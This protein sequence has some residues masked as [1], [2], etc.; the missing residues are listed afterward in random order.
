MALTPDCELGG[1]PPGRLESIGILKFLLV[2]ILYSPGPQ[3]SRLE[4]R[5][6]PLAPIES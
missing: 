4:L 6:A 2:V 1:N 5:F 3:G